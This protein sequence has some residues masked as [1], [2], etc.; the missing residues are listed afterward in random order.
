MGEPKALLAWEGE[1]LLARAARVAR[2]ATGQSVAVSLP[3]RSVCGAGVRR[4]ACRVTERR[5]VVHD[6]A[7]DR[8]PAA[9]VLAALDA[10]DTEWIVWLAVDMPW[11]EAA[12]IRHL[13]DR[14][15]SGAGAA[16]ARYRGRVQPACAVLHR[17]ALPLARRA[18]A[19]RRGLIW[20]LDAAGA[21][22]VSVPR[23]AGASP[24]AS[25]DT[26][27]AWRT[28]VRKLSRPAF[29]ARS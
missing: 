26:P 6:S 19:Q 24:F 22:I 18:V 21:A 13:L 15:P 3:H 14:V 7:P 25:V 23:R 12:V 11:L 8:G 5:F 27:A 4:E 1:S 9:G 2:E 17:A 16:V 28:Q 10:V 20:L 29:D